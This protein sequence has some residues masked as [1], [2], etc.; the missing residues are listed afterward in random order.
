MKNIVLIIDSLVGGG[1]EKTNLNLA[2]I[3]INNGFNVTIIIIKNKIEYKIDNRINL[4]SLNYAK[5]S[6]PK[7]LRNYYYAKKLDNILSKISNTSLIIG[8]LS[9]SNSLM[10]L[11][12]NK[13]NFYYSLHSTMTI[14][15]FENKNFLNKYLK[16]LELIKIYNNKNIICVSEGVKE[17]ILSLPIKPK[18]IQVIYN[19]FDFDEILNK[20]KEK[21]DFNFPDEYIV[22]VGRFAKVKRHDILLKAFSKINNKTIKLV[23]VGQG[24]EK[25]NIKKLIKDLNL[26]KR[27]IFSGFQK[28]PFPIIK[29]AKALI[30][31]SQREGLPTVLI[32]S[33]ILGT[34]IV[35]TNCPSGPKEIME[36]Y[37]K[38][39]LAKV[40][41]YTDLANKINFMLENLKKIDRN[42]I[43][44]FEMNEIIKKYI[45]IIEEKNNE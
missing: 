4:I 32:E 44:K 23:L 27:V 10:N 35:S 17:D 30:L 28:N 14:A 38:E 19:P 2:E 24:E 7:F 40:N 12:N 9:L 3:F 43:K 20:S 13:Y 45:Q 16:K 1:A 36:D 39:Y 31:S 6:M 8:S 15:K 37:L 42:L 29:N 26:E 21:I 18:S 11:I 41:D 34:P 22:H 5:N 25:D 33:L